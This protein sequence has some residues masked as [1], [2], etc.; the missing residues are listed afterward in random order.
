MVQK[1]FLKM[2]SSFEVFK[3]KIVLS[4]DLV[5]R[6]MGSYKYEFQRGLIL[7]PAV[8][9]WNLGVEFSKFKLLNSTPKFQNSTAG[10]EISHFEFRL[11]L[12]HYVVLVLKV[13]VMVLKCHIEILSSRVSIVLL[14]YQMEF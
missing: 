13:V 2:R 9:L 6:L 5:P 11:I 4:N 8:E 10:V 14:K 1:S 3:L 7:T 12:S